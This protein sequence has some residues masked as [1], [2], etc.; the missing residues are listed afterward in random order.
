MLGEDRTKLEALLDVALRSSSNIRDGK[1][2]MSSKDAAVDDIISIQV[3]EAD[4]A[5]YSAEVMMGLMVPSPD[6]PRSRG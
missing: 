2:S 4:M 3:G 5:E 1:K 6:E